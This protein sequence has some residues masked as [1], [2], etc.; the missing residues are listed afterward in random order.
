MSKE[1]KTGILIGS[2]SVDSKVWCLRKSFGEKFQVLAYTSRISNRA[3]LELCAAISYILKNDFSSV[4]EKPQ[5]MVSIL[6]DI[7]ESTR[8]LGIPVSLK[9]YL[10]MVGGEGGEEEK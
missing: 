8:E 4:L 6:S 9:E 1:L 5:I 2:G 3:E 7:I 10:A